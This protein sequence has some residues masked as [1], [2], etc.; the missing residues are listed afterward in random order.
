MVDGSLLRR[1]GAIRWADVEIDGA[2]KRRAL[3]P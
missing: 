2:E 1:P 3:V